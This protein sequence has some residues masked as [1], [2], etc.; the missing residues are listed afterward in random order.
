MSGLADE[1]K[2]DV[3]GRIGLGEHGSRG[4][5]EHVVL[6]HPGAFRGFDGNQSSLIMFMFLSSLIFVLLVFYRGLPCPQCHPV[7]EWG[8][9]FPGF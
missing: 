7:W 4:L 6:R 8:D 2:R 9:G 1:H 5:H 3:V